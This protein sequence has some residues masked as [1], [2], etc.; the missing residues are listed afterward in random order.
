MVTEFGKLLP[1]CETSQSALPTED[2][3][4]NLKQS[5]PNTHVSEQK[6]SLLL[7]S[8]TTKE[9]YLKAIQEMYPLANIGLLSSNLAIYEDWDNVRAVAALKA[10]TAVRKM[11]TEKKLVYDNRTSLSDDESSDGSYASYIQ[12]KPKK[13]NLD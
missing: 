13:V 10:F 1:E 6:Q 11:I 3:S 2:K 12:K 9:M 8:L 7:K 4:V 5:S